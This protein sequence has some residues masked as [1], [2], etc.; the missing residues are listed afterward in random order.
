MEQIKPMQCYIIV[1][2]LNIIIF[3]TY[4]PNLIL[5]LYRIDYICKILH[6]FKIISYVIDNSSR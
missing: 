4:L 2:P 6:K 5:S 1:T 3:N